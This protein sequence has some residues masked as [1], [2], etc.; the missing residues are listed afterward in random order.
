MRVI[1]S[2]GQGRLHLI[3]SAKAIKNAGADLKVITGWVPSMII[4]DF[5]LDTFGKI[6][7]S[8][9]TAFGLRKRKPLDF[10]QKEINKCTLSEFLF[11]FFLL[12]SNV[13]IITKNSATRWGWT[14]FGWQ[15][16][17]YIRNA[18][19]FHC[20]SGAGHGGAI[21]QARRLGMKIVIDQS[22]AH[23]DLFNS[24]LIKANSFI[25][26]TF[27]VKPLSD[28]W[29]LVKNDCNKADVL[30]VNSEFV[31]QSFIDNGYDESKI[32]VCRLGVRTDFIGLKNNY[33]S[34]P[35]L[36]IL[37]TGTFSIGKGCLVIID[38]IL[39]LIKL[40]IEFQVDI[41]G[42]IPDIKI[43]P[44]WFVNDQ[45]VVL[46]GH[47]PQDELLQYL[48]FSDIYI[49]PSYCEGSAQ[50]LNEAMAAGLPVIATI[51]SGAPIIHELNGLIIRDGN[52]DDLT[53]SIIKLSIAENLREILGT[54]AKKII[55]ES[56]TWSHYGQSLFNFYEK[57]V[58]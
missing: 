44:D 36:K 37:F 51:Q 49:F 14:F 2:T 28:L 31:K 19:I 10:T 56:S 48:K 47:I 17:K 52:A 9:N 6:V 23:P 16:K 3:E 50:S 43:L 24:Q 22:A 33:K 39:Q 4:P 38:S 34:G 11:H 32:F 8:K 46:H 21:D 42:S 58:S 53:N 29:V 35:V 12:L 40:N 54:N 55:Q 25:S 41:T 5:V 30:L 1:I 15:S 13:K 7:G 57:L 20:R 45:R 18:D 26:N 27:D